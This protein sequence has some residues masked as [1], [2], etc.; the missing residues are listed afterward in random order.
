MQSSIDTRPSHGASILSDFSSDRAFAT[1]ITND[2]YAR[3]VRLLAFTIFRTLRREALECG[4]H[5][6][7]LYT[8]DVSS[9]CIDQ[10]LDASGVPRG[11]IA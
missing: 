8:A 7:V 4:A 1:L 9:R 11:F 2:N 10:I 5:L 6:L 3:A